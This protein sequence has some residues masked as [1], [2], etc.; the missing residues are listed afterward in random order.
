[1]VSWSSVSNSIHF[2]HG[3]QIGETEITQSR[4]DCAKQNK[5]ESGILSTW[6]Q[7]EMPVGEKGQRRYMAADATFTFLSSRSPEKE[8]SEEH[9]TVERDREREGERRRER[10]K[11]WARHEMSY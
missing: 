7:T 5:V 6:P 11:D 10:E 1:M 2:Q 8:V 9:K 4:Q 3:A